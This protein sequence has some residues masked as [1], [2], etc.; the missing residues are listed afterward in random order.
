MNIIIL[1]IALNPFYDGSFT[2]RGQCATAIFENPSGLG[3]DPKM[4]N[5]TTLH[6][7]S[8][9]E[10]ISLKGIGLG[11]IKRDSNWTAEAGLG[12]KLPGAF[13]LGYAYRFSVKGDPLKTHYLGIGCRPNSEMSLG[14]T[15]T[16]ARTKYLHGGLSIMPAGDLLTLSVDFDY[17]GR[18]GEFRYYLG[19]MVQL[20]GIVNASFRMDDEK[21]WTAGLGF[22]YSV[23]RL[24]AAY[25]RDR[26]FG[27]GLIVGEEKP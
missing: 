24:A 19:G 16:L 1:L 27:I 3:Y 4:E 22:G 10:G 26:K 15:T 20:G 12:F 21:Q 25:G 11:L 7:D 6:R 18:S 2:S 14:F 13:A 5:M 9:I 23:F 8:I 17:E